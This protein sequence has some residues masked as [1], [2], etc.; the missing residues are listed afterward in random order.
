MMIN[1]ILMMTLTMMRKTMM[2]MMR[3]VVHW[4]KVERGNC[5]RE[6]FPTKIKAHRYYDDDYD[7]DNMKT[8]TFDEEDEKT[9]FFL[10]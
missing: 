5:S 6:R 10:D 4:R 1:M 8:M 3:K 2:R 7:N 9:F